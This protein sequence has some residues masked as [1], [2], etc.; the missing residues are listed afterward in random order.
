MYFF[1]NV[2]TGKRGK[3]YMSDVITVEK[4]GPNVNVPIIQKH[5]SSTADGGLDTT[6]YDLLVVY[7]ADILRNMNFSLLE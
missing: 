6:F 7:S 4:L 3:K 2:F 1:V 5:S